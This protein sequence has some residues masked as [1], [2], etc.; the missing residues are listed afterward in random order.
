MPRFQNHT[1]K[2][3]ATLQNLYRPAGCHLTDHNLETLPLQFTTQPP[4]NF[5]ALI[6]KIRGQT[7]QKIARRTGL[8]L[9]YTQGVSVF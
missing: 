7:Q 8:K 4:K 2:T 9:L 6:K 1:V 5:E 3:M